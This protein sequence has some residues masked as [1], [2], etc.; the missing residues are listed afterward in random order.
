VNRSRFVQSVEISDGTI[1]ITY[2]RGA[3]PR[4]GDYLLSLRPHVMHDG[5]IA[6]QC[7]NAA[8]PTAIP[9][10]SG[11]GVTSL[12]DRDMPASCRTGYGGY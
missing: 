8:P 12:E 1:V 6:W 2:G 3:S 4:I 5:R 9:P 7:G 10:H 11:V